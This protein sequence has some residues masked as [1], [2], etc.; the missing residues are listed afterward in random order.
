MDVPAVAPPSAP[1]PADRAAWPAGAVRRPRRLAA[2]LLLVQ[3]VVILGFCVFYVVELALGA[4]AD[5]TQTAMS[6]VTFLVGA[7]CLAAVA[8][9]LWRGSPWARTPAVLWNVLVMFICVSLAQS[10]QLPAAVALGLVAVGGIAGVLLAPAVA[11]SG[12]P[13]PS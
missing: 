9:G 1:P 12:G 7:A 5:A 13:G 11:R 4:E 10:G 8:R 3:V 2:V 6:V